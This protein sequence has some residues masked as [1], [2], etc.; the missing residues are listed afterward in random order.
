[1][2]A[3]KQERMIDNID[4]DVEITLVDETQGRMN[5]KDMFGVND[6]DGD[7]VIVDATTGEEVD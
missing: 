4:K 3:S 1:E 2:G 7:E 5:E 6:L